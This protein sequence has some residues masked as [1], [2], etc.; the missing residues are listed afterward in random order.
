MAE[1]LTSFCVD[2]VAYDQLTVSPQMV[3]DLFHQGQ[4]MRKKPE[5][6]SGEV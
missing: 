4:D 5:A 6:V 3:Q 1:A 2:V